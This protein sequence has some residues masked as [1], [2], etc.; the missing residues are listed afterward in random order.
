M[1]TK[2]PDS[3]EF[4]MIIIPY[5]RS[6]LLD[7]MNDFPD[8][9]NAT[10]HKRFCGRN[11]TQRTIHTYYAIVKNKGIAVRQVPHNGQKDSLYMN[12]QKETDMM[13]MIRVA[14]PK[15]ICIN[16]RDNADPRDRE[17]LKCFLQKLW[18]KPAEW[19]ITS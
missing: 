3:S 4:E 6:V 19:E 18:P 14:K 17:N 10:S 2:Y 9:F 12:I 13:E 8:E 1:R 16:D 15:I 11:S 7:C 5:R